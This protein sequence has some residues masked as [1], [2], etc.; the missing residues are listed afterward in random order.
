MLVVEEEEI[1]QDQQLEQEGKVEVVLLEYM[2]QQLQE[3]VELMQQEAVA[4]QDLA[5]PVYTMQLEQ[6]VVPVS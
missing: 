5:R 4:V 3:L 6:T 1:I 2:D